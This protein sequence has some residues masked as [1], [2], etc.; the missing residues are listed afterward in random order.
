MGVLVADDQVPFY[1]CMPITLVFMFLFGIAI[2][3]DHLV[4]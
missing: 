2:Q 4:T 1:S 3:I